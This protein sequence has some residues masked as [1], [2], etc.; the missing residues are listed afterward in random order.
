MK[1]VAEIVGEVFDNLVIVVLA[2]A[3]GF[4]VASIGLESQQKKEENMF[5]T[6]YEAI[7][8]H[9]VEPFYET[10]DNVVSLVAER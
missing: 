4:G 10:V 6:A 8:D 5:R 9:V 7:E 1:K 3:I 2:F